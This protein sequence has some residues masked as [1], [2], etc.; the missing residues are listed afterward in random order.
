ML[1]ALNIGAVGLGVGAGGLTATAVAFVVGAGLRFAGL[2]SG[3]DIGLVLGVL[4]GLAMAGWVAGRFAAHSER[5]HGAVTGLVLAGL[6][7]VVARLGGSPA[8][9][10]SVVWLAL[11]SALI[12]G[13]SGWLCG[14]RKRPS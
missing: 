5:F 9:T 3:P 14:R 4:T 12:G 10:I 11:I 13:V 8:D 1:A 6:V 7:V 2:E